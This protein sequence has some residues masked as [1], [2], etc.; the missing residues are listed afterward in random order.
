MRRFAGPG[1]A[2]RDRHRVTSP[3]G[4]WC[5][6]P[7]SLQVRAR[8]ADTSNGRCPDLA[9]ALRGPG[10]GPRTTE[11]GQ[12]LSG[13][14]SS[15]TSS[16][17]RPSP[18]TSAG[19]TASTPGASTPPASSTPNRLVPRAGHEHRRS[20]SDLQQVSRPAGV[21][22]VRPGRRPA[23]RGHLRR[24]LRPGPTRRARC[25]PPGRL[26]AKNR[27]SRSPTGPS[28]VRAG[29]SEG[30]PRPRQR[31]RRGRAAPPRSAVRL[32]RA[33]AS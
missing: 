12:V 31:R 16:S 33:F 20:Q 8:G 24:H 4:M 27:P 32:L 18:P 23:A 15:S 14:C 25:R 30:C 13:P 10:A 2:E 21:P 22:P 11:L 9:T 3:A 6:A 5:R 19:S 26:N 17:P 1:P 7:E 29:P 28:G